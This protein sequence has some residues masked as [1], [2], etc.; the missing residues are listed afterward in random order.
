M[1]SPAT[2]LYMEGVMVKRMT[3][4]MV[5]CSN[6]PKAEMSLSLLIVLAI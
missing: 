6:V 4:A 2:H 5:S 1:P 3:I